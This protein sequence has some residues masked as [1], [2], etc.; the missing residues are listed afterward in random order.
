MSSERVHRT[1]DR[2]ARDHAR[3]TPDYPGQILCPLCLTP[4]GE[5]ALDLDDPL[6]TEEHVIPGEL[7]GRIV[8]LSCKSCNNTHGT[9]YRL[10]FDR[11]GSF[12]GH[13]WTEE[14]RGLFAATSR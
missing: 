3:V 2:L 7:G 12:K 8:T 1:F 14:E 6:L 9:K 13:F 11:A 4:Y 5:D 10:P